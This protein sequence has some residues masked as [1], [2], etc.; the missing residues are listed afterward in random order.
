MGSGS[1]AA[2]AVFESG[3]KEDLTVSPR[4]IR[5]EEIVLMNFEA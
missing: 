5:V 4:I 2:M 1:M 3:Y